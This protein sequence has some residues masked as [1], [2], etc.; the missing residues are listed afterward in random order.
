[1]FCWETL[2]PGI[3]LDVTTTVLVPDTTGHPQ[4]LC[5]YPDGSELFWQTYS[6]SFYSFILLIT[7]LLFHIHNQDFLNCK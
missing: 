4:V 7:Y 2:G 5:P 6:I 3:Y 1:M